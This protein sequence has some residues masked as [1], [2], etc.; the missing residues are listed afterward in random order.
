ME[1]FPRNVVGKT[2]KWVMRELYRVGQEKQI[3]RI[4]KQ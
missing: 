2:L 1:D 3:Q 4:N